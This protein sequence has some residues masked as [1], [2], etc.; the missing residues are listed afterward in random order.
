M[1]AR[2]ILFL[3]TDAALGVVQDTFSQRSDTQRDTG[4]LFKFLA[5][6]SPIYSLMSINIRVMIPKRRVGGGG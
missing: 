6:K 4:L 3:L 1:C 5:A 2:L